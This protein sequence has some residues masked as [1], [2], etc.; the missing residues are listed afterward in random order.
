MSHELGGAM[1]LEQW[2][3]MNLSCALW[4]RAM[5]YVGY[6]LSHVMCHEP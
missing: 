4:A 5:S 3:A 6:E 2:A 1:N